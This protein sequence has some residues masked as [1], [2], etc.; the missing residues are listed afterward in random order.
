MKRNFVI[1]ANNK[2]SQFWD[3]KIEEFGYGLFQGHFL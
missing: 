2:L 1:L 3:N